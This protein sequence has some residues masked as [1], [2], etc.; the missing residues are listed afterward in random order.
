MLVGPS[1][2]RQLSS[3]PSCIPAS[4]N[5]CFCLGGA[6]GSDCSWWVDTGY[7]LTK[8]LQSRYPFCP[9][10]FPSFINAKTVHILQ[11]T[12]LAPG[13][14]PRECCGKSHHFADW[15]LYFWIDSSSTDY[16]CLLLRRHFSN[17]TRELLRAEQCTVSGCFPHPWRVFLKIKSSHFTR[18]EFILLSWH[19]ECDAQCDNL[20]W[21]NTTIH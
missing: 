18:R 19:V 20:K 21:G 14:S 3:G 7:P 15:M 10:L 6:G 2:C 17:T 5:L 13:N 1:V 12:L 16:Y 11:E 9:V 8:Q 4:R